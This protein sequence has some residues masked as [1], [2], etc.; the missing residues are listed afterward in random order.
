MRVLHVV[1]GGRGG[2]RL[3]EQASGGRGEREQREDDDRQRGQAVERL[4]QAAEVGA[5]D[6]EE[7]A[8]GHRPDDEEHPARRAGKQ[9]RGH[10]QRAE[11]GH[12]EVVRRGAEALVDGGGDR[13]RGD[14]GEGGHE[15]H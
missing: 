11:Q 2:R 10:E 15:R 6:G 8:G 3:P 1:G 12:H 9:H 13:D 4:A 14:R 7:G 5:G